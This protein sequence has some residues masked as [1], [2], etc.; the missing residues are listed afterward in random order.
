ML[1]NILV[2]GAG[3]LALLLASN[4]LSAK[5]GP[6]HRMS[7]SQAP[8]SI[9]PN[10][11]SAEPSPD[12]LSSTPNYQDNKAQPLMHGEGFNYDL[13][14]NYHLTPHIVLRPNLQQTT[15]PGSVEDN[16]QRFVG[17]LSAGIKF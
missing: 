10:S 17:G 1:C 7:E 16:S 2:S 14:Y 6:Q 11:V 4:T 8:Y 13:Y 15:K 12:N 9:Y 3:A 5:T